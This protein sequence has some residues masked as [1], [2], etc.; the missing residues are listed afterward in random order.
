MQKLN[1]EMYSAILVQ[2]FYMMIDL[3]TRPSMMIYKGLFLKNEGETFPPLQCQ[4]H[5]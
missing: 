3:N 5:H 4:K 2:S 1:V